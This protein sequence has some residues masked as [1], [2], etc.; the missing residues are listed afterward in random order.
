M[1]TQTLRNCYAGLVSLAL[2]GFLVGCTT[3]PNTSAPSPTVDSASS[4]NESSSQE[5]PAIVSEI[6]QQPVWVQQLNATNEISAEQGI[7]LR[8][9]EK[10]RTHKEAVAQVDFK[11][12]LAFRMGGDSL[13]TLEP[14]N[15]LKLSEGEILVWVDPAKKVPTEIIT[16][17]VIAKLQGTTVSVK[18]LKELDNAVEIFVWEGT[19]TV[20]IP[21]QQGELVIKSGQEVRIWSG[22][23]DIRQ[24]SQRVRRV[25]YQDWSQRRFQSPL[26][27]NFGKPLPTLLALDQAAPPVAAPETSKVGR[28]RELNPRQASTSRSTSPRLNQQT[29]LGL[30][31]SYPIASRTKQVSRNQTVASTPA[32]RPPQKTNAQNRRTGSSTEP[33]KLDL[34]I[35]FRD[36]QSTPTPTPSPTQL[37][38]PEQIET[39]E[40]IRRLFRQS[41]SEV[42]RGTPTP[43]PTQ[44]ARPQTGSTNNPDP[45]LIRQ[46][47]PSMERNSPTPSL[48][49]P[50]TPEGGSTDSPGRPS[51]RQTSPSIE[52]NT[53]SASP[54]EQTLPTNRPTPSESQNQRDINIP[55]EQVTPVEKE[56]RVPVPSPTLSPAESPTP[57]STNPLSRPMEE[58][59]P[60]SPIPGKTDRAE[61]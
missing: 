55:I 16:P 54:T 13:V 7:S 3:T 30:G 32:R 53:P 45:A 8:A 59:T 58:A 31:N 19:V 28:T 1:K 49:E 20:Q 39:S 57:E 56:N 50:V 24:I 9:G 12:G 29:N 48:T 5:A 61:D 18:V 25:P 47:N 22:E 43:S 2:S 38:S 51:I 14:N 46:I 21:K 17:G 40:T 27:N 15:H 36:P 34:G 37:T 52:R 26:L 41:N 33:E 60:A 35:Y 11:N 4:Q 10:I 6:S 23:T 42:N 44:Q